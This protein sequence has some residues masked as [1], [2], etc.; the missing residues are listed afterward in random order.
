[1]KTNMSI[2]QTIKEFEKID[3]NEWEESYPDKIKSFLLRSHLNYLLE[4]KKR[5]EGEIIP[6]IAD[7]DYSKKGGIE[8]RLHLHPTLDYRYNG[9]MIEG[10]NTAITQQ[11]EHLEEEIKETKELL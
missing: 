6:S 10:F 4:E 1:M 7:K 11:L 9:G 5:L 8:K 2:T 3:M